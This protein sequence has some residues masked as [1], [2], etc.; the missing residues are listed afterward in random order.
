[1]SAR[2]GARIVLVLVLV[3]VLLFLSACGNSR[4]RK[5]SC[6]LGREY[7]QASDYSQ[8]MIRIRECLNEHPDDPDVHAMLAVIYHNDDKRQREYKAELEKIKQMGETGTASPAAATRSA[9]DRFCDADGRVAPT[10][11]GETKFG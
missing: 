2:K 4:K 9:G 10:E 11:A 8:A 7:F 1:M 3:L 5:T 6:E